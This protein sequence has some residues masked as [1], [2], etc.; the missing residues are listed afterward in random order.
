MLP[1]RSIDFLGG[2]P[3]LRFEINDELSQRVAFDRAHDLPRIRRIRL[4]DISVERRFA[5]MQQRGRD[6]DKNDHP[7]QNSNS[8]KRRSSWHVPPMEIGRVARTGGCVL[9]S[10]TRPLATRSA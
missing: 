3:G 8:W 10:I 7:T 9:R 1:H 5:G 4:S 2:S 6:E